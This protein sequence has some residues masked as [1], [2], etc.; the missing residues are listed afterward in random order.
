MCGIVGLHLRTPISTPG[1]AS[2]SPACSARCRTA[3]RTPPGSQSTATPVVA[4]G[5]CTVSVLD[6]RRRPMAATRSA[7]DLG[8]PV[9]R[10]HRRSADA[11]RSNVARGLPRHCGLPYARPCPDALVIGFGEDLAVLKGVG[12]PATWPTALRP[13]P[14]AGLAGR[15][16]HAD[17]DRVGRNAGRVPPVRRRARS[18]PG[19]QRLLPQLPHDPP[20]PHGPGYDA[21]TPRTT[22]RSVPASW[23]SA[24]RTAST[25]RPRSRSSVGRS[26]ASTRCS[27]RTATRSRSSAT[28][29]PASRP[30]SPRPTTGWRWPRSTARW[31]ACPASSRPH[32][33][34]RARAGLRMDTLTPQSGHHDD[35]TRF[36][37]TTTTLREVN[38]RC[39]PRPWPRLRRSATR[40]AST[41]SRSASTP[42][43]VTVDGHVGYY[44]A[45][46]NQQAEVIIDGNVGIGVAENMMSGV[47]SGDRQ[48]LAVRRR[49][50]RT[51]ACWSSTAT[52]RPLRHLDEGHR[53]RR[54]RQ[55]RPHERLHGPGRAAR[56]PRR[57]R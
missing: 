2:C 10:G 20:R 11:P 16:A 47:R 8:E 19:A 42:R 56:R 21:S 38:A 48:R 12:H 55:R 7:Q 50:G 57:R 15:R 39:T 17:G 13:A 18:V 14:G 35:R 3:A 30:S 52:R 36:D 5:T 34:A 41:A 49:D 51:A 31:S 54:R 44:A 32:L 37:L 27:S 45:G 53:H 22:P 26:T 28:R 25:S 24:S 40:T 43:S 33:R 6:A 4:P 9:V 1:S 29:S 23:R 46:M